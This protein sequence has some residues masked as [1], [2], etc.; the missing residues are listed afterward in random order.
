M[1]TAPS[2]DIDGRI[3]FVQTAAT[4]T[5]L[6]LVGNVR[7]G[8][9]AQPLAFTRDLL[10]MEHAPGLDSLYVW[11]PGIMMFNVN[12]AETLTWALGI[13]HDTEN[14]LGFGFGDGKIDVSGRLTWLAWYEDE[15]RELVHLGFGASRREIVN[16]QIRLRGRPSVRTMPASVLPDLADTGVINAQTQEVFNLEL[17]ALYGPWNFRSQYF[18]T[19]LHHVD[20]APINDGT[21]F[22]QGAYVQMNYS[23]TGEAQGYNRKVGNFERLV[24]FNNF[25]AR[26]RTLGA[27]QSRCP[28]QYLDL[29]NQGVNGPR[30]TTSSSG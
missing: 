17:A 15:G 22:C 28:L 23:L 27:W 2:N 26:Q 18:T 4:L 11:A 12:E 6:P 25:E 21:L 7:V 16:D 10:F 5:E 29:Q 3:R 9:F 20:N 14:T 24:P 30:S 19:F 13:F 1:T 8:F